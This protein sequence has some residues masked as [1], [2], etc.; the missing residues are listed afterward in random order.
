MNIS[1]KWLKQYVDFDLTPEELASLLTSPDS[2]PDRSKK[3]NVDPR[4]CADWS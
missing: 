4:G 3:W 2:K 1:Y